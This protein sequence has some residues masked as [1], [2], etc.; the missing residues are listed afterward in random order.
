MGFGAAV[1]SENPAET[2]GPNPVEP[3]PVNPGR[4]ELEAIEAMDGWYCACIW[5]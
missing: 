5:P 1:E 2:A 4:T 3:R